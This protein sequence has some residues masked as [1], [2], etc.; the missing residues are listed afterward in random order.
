M[1]SAIDTGAMVLDV[2]VLIQYIINTMVVDQR[3]SC[4]TTSASYKNSKTGASSDERLYHD[5][6]EPDRSVCAIYHLACV[7]F[8]PA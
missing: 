2:V 5:H 4:N 1:L 8:L 3:S 6:P 7:I